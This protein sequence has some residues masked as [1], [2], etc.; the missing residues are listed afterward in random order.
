M[1]YPRSGGGALAAMSPADSIARGEKPPVAP[2]KARARRPP[3]GNIRADSLWAA[4]GDEDKRDTVCDWLFGEGLNFT[5]C[6][7]QI[8][9]DYGVRTTVAAVKFFYQQHTFLWKVGRAKSQ[10]EIEKDKLP[11]GWEASVRQALAQRRFEATFQD[12]TQQQII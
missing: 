12:L 7:R 9:E 8:D 11:P 4:L 10:A 1:D 5:Q 3:L 6:A 2:K